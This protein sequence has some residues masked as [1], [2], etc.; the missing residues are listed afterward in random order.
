M[1][2]PCSVRVGK[3]GGRT[4]PLGDGDDDGRLRHPRQGDRLLH[5]RE[6]AA[7]GGRHGPDAGIGGPQGHVDRGDLVLGLLEMDGESRRGRREVVQDRGGGRHR[8]AGHELA[9]AEDGAEGQGLVAVELAM[10][11][12][13]RR[14]GNG[15]GQ[16]PLRGELE[17]LPQ[18]L[19]FPGFGRLR[20]LSRAIRR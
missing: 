12:G 2:S 5:E 4:G 7:G 10:P 20:Q 17:T 19:R 16:F 14:H 8:V 18:V 11:T 15:P 3:T 1:R 13:Q 6:A 9:A